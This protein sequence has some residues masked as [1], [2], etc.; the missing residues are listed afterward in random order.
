[1]LQVCVGQGGFFDLQFRQLREFPNL[2]RKRG[3]LV[4]FEIQPDQLGELSNL[5]RERGE[6]VSSEPQIN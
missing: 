1:M 3:E 6:L 2:G 5:R 4:T